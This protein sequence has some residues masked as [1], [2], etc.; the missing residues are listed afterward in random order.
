MIGGNRMEHI[1]EQAAEAI[2]PEGPAGNALFRDALFRKHKKS[3]WTVEE[4]PNPLLEHPVADTHAHIH[5]LANPALSLARCAVHNVDFLCEIVDPAEDGRLPYER[6]D[7]WRAEALRMLPEVFS[8]TRAAC[9]REREQRAGAGAPL[10]EE[11][12]A[13]EWRVYRCP[14]E[15]VAIPRVRFAAGV[16]PHNARLWSDDIERSLRAMLADERT[17]A[18]G[19]VG[20]DYHYDLSPRAVQ[21]DVF[22]RQIALAHETGLP[23]VLHMRD[24]HEDGFALLEREGWPAAG[25]LLH[26]CSVG[27]EELQRWIDRGCFVAFGGAVTFAR[28]EDLR[29]SAHIVAEGALLTETDSPY[30]AP[31]P[32]RGLECGPEYSIFVAERLAAERG[33]AAGEPRAAF[34]RRMHDAALGLLNRGATPWQRA[35]ALCAELS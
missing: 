30:M 9:E 15:E 2:D 12:T 11:L 31:V 26:C 3:G 18:L 5:M 16:H 27:P 22:A 23:L 25:V 6:M 1:E 8:A 32:F 28:S 34:L 4:S 13:D 19:E 33:V 14:C 29:A 20:L 24:A 10:P 7:A 35:E 17:A 21:R